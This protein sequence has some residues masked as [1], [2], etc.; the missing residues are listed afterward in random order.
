[1]GEFDHKVEFPR[2]EGGRVLDEGDKVLGE[3]DRVLDEGDSDLV[4]N[5]VRDLVGR[6]E[7]E[8]VLDGVD[9]DDGAVLDYAEARDDLQI[10]L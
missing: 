2:G 8:K 3:G 1:M 6:D 4:D 7:E 9:C 5:D 10:Y